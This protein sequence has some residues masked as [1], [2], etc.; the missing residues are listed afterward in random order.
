MTSTGQSIKIYVIMSELQYFMAYI[1]IKSEINYD[2]R[3]T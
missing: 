1:N 3:S 2:C